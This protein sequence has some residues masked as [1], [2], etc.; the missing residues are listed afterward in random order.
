MRTTQLWNPSKYLL[1]GWDY[2]G[3]RR[4]NLYLGF[5]FLTFS[6]FFFSVGLHI[7]GFLSTELRIWYKPFKITL[8]VIYKGKKIR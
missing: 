8:P 4:L 1:F 7:E 3:G 5:L 6:I 2:A